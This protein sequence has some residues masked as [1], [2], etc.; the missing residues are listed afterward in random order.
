M[1]YVQKFFKA[2][3]KLESIKE[4]I[5][6]YPKDTKEVV[7][8]KEK[9][10]FLVLRVLYRE[11]LMEEKI[12]ENQDFFRYVFSFATKCAGKEK[13]LDYFTKKEIKKMYKCFY[14]FK[15]FLQEHGHV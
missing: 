10:I 7:S 11:I 2:T 1:T 4:K 13:I 9:A 5:M 8:E 14:S 3:N 12:P 6:I 15:K